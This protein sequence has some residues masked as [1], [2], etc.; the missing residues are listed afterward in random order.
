MRS[1]RSPH[2]PVR[3]G[4]IRLGLRR[5][6]GG[7]AK[8]RQRRERLSRIQSVGVLIPPAFRPAENLPSPPQGRQRDGNVFER[9]GRLARSGFSPSLALL[10]SLLRLGL[11]PGS[12]HGSEGLAARVSKDMGMTP[13]ELLTNRAGNILK[14]KKLGLL[15]QLGVI[16]HLQQKVSEFVSEVFHIVPR[17]RVG[18]FI[19]LFNRVRRNRF[20]TLLQVPRAT[21]FGITKTGHDGQKSIDFRHVRP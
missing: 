16:D 19:R 13:D 1:K 2:L 12:A 10:F 5:L 17:N 4:Q 18:D 20:E 7:L 9:V 11:F 21:G 6:P 3:L 14:P 8:F 15:S